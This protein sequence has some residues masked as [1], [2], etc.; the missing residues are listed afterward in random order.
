MIKNPIPCLLFCGRLSSI[1][2]YFDLN[3]DVFSNTTVIKA[4]DVSSSLWLNFS[5]LVES[6]YIICLISSYL[7]LHSFFFVLVPDINI[8]FLSFLFSMIFC[9]LHLSWVWSQ[10]KQLGWVFVDYFF[11]GFIYAVNQNT[12]YTSSRR[13]ER[14][15][16]K[17]L[18]R[19]VTNLIG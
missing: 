4:P 14:Y 18:C 6:S 1:R 10:P 3:A 12:S 2:T 9:S 5:V 17:T 19:S 11:P 13:W 16:R 8:D 7:L 15:Q